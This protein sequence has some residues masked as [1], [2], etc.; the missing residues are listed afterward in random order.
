MQGVAPWALV[1]SSLLVLASQYLSS[2]GGRAER[3]LLSSSTAA[4]HAVLAPGGLFSP[5]LAI[6]SVL[7]LTRG[8]GGP[9]WFW[10]PP[11]LLATASLLDPALGFSLS[12]SLTAYGVVRRR[13]GGRVIATACSGLGAGLLAAPLSP[14]SPLPAGAPEALLYHAAVLYLLWA[15]LSASRPPGGGLLVLL[16]SG[17]GLLSLASTGS[18]LVVSP[19]LL[20]SWSLSSAGGL[21]APGRA[22]LALAAAVLAA[23]A[24]AG[25]NV[26][27]VP[28]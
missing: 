4:Y 23:S 21:P 5:G 24:L 1:A 19:A 15:G 13:G 20:G 11:A 22:A 2:G 16:A 10:G 28:W 17:A 9:L 18:A 14:A 25:Q 7:L 3:L 27:N 26:I 8:G 6:A 12:A